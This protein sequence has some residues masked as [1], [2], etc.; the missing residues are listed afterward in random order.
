MCLAQGPQHSDAGEAQTRGP[1]VSSQAP[2]RSRA[3]LVITEYS[4]S[5]RRLILLLVILV[6]N[7]T[8]HLLRIHIIFNYN[9]KCMLIFSVY[10]KINFLI[11][12][13][14]HMLWV[15]KRTVSMRRFFSAPKLYVKAYGEE[16]CLQF[17][18][19]NFCF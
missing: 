12:Q 3:G 16:N 13:P 10:Q 14:K 9:P 5:G 19:Q 15:L 4:G 2:L 11:Y 7:N 18:P 6:T 17:E 1:S 8:L